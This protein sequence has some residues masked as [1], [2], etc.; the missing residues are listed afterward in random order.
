MELAI[1]VLA[2]LAVVWVPGAIATRLLRVGH[3]DRIVRFA[4]EIALGLSFW[5]ILFLLTSTLGLSWSANGARLLVGG[6][7]A[8]LVALRIRDARPFRRPDLIEGSAV[9]LAT[10]VAY[11]RVRQIDGIALPLWVDSVHHTMIV[12]LLVEQGHLPESYAP[13]IP[14]SAFYYHWGFHAVAAFVAWLSGLTEGGEIARM[15]LA[16]GQSLNV[17]VFFAVYCGGAALFRSR[18]TALLAATLATLVSLFPA[19][20]VSWGRYTQL[21]GLLLLPPLA[22]AF[23]R[24]GRHPTMRR[25]VEVA[26]LGGG[27]ALIHVRVSLV[28]AI[29]ASILVIILA[30]QRRWNGLAW[31]GLAGAASLLIALPWIVQLVRAPQ[32]RMIIAPAADERAQW[33]SSNAAP[34]DIVWVPH[35]AFLFAL[36]SGGLFGFTPFRIGTAIR[37]AAIVWWLA[38]IALLQRASTRVR[39]RV[40]RRDAWR[41]AILAAWVGITA[42]LINLDAVGL[43][44]VRAMTNSAAII[45]LFLPLSIAGAH[46][47]RWVADQIFRPP[48]RRLV[49]IAATFIIGIV[50]ASRTLHIVNPT[51]VLATA[52]DRSALEWIRVN[53]PAQR[54]FA[55]GVQPWI[56]GSFRGID[57]GYWIPLVAER[58]SIL[59]PG[60]YPW[61]MPRERAASTTR[62]L[63]SWYEAQQKGD[64]AVVEQLR[65]AGVTHVY[66]GPANRT[67]IRAAMAAVP[68]ASRIY[69]EDGVQ[70]YALVNR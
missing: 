14:E 5:P 62:L 42:A 17:L 36:A 30:I 34:A 63:T 7:A 2:G 57:G 50:G 29:L 54:R 49:L 3:R 64:T 38:L 16:F 40:A 8:W 11:T 44:R 33:E 45:M 53:V 4:H 61:V 19:Y 69:D 60:L 22:F 37:V 43:P 25:A 32:V 68:I 24:L 12:R 21:C 10:L 56:S 20:Y 9:V 6:L 41:L 55:V 67:A 70:I 48:R 39:R 1:A 15:L 27:L 66:F 13:F 65:R 26:I 23:W 18:R 31:C 59:P 35:N 58:E 51:T 52:A 47:V 46:L 28:F